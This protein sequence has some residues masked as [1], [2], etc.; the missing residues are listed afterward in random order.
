MKPTV[1]LDAK[2][3]DIRRV[4]LK[5]MRT[6]ATLLLLGMTALF[7]LAS[8]A[9]STW[10]G[11]A[12]VRAFSE[13]GMVGACA[14]WFAVVALFR[15]PLGLPIPHTAVVPSNKQRIGGALGRFI[16]N[17]FL[18]PRIATQR[19]A[20]VDAAGWIAEWLSHDAHASTLAAAATRVILKGLEGVPRN[21][22]AGFWATA[23]K[24]GVE[25]APAAPIASRV[26][27][28]VWA[29]GQAQSWLEQALDFG[30]AALLRN[31]DFVVRKVS[32]QSSRWIPRWVDAI[33]A[34]KVMNGLLSSIREMH[35]EDHP[36]RKELSQAVERLIRDLADDPE[37]YARGEAMKAE[38]LSSPVFL[39]QV[40]TLWAEIDQGL[41]EELPR[42]ADDLTTLIASALTELSRWLADDPVRRARINRMARQSLLRLLLP[43][44]AEIG[45]YFTAVV[46]N[47]DT[48]TLVT[49]LELQVGKDLQYIRINGTIVGGLAGLAIF[50]ASQFFAR[51]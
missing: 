16:T 19:L 6:I 14:D 32:E 25:A 34:A 40:K 48:A 49:R 12:Y 33:I 21:A 10:A 35:D 24:R 29:G 44:R 17:N 4:E 5:R 8:L 39:E 50:T 3:R 38:L 41:R 47:W 36:W 31:K 27:K 23:A 28:V 9:P 22:L 46:E 15:R 7:V 45:A 20:R 51:P 18:S 30:E 13:A 37:F 1:L 2:G 11:L 43:R 26:L 42:R